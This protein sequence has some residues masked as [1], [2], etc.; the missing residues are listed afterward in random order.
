MLGFILVMILFFGIIGGAAFFAVKQVQKT[1]PNNVG[2]SNTD[3]VT[4]NSDLSNPEAKND[5]ENGLSAQQF[6]PYESI[7]HDVIHLGG[8]RYR[9]FIECGSINYNTATEDEQN[10][11]EYTFQRFLNSIDFPITFFVQTRTIDN[12]DRLEKIKEECEK[13]MKEYPDIPTLSKYCKKYQ[14]EM[15]HL[16]NITQNNKQKK[17]YIIIPYDDA[18]SFEHLNEEEKYQYAMKEIYNRCVII[19]ERLRS[20]RIATHILNTKEIYELV[21][22]T[23]SKD[24]YSDISNIVEK[25]IVP[26][27]VTAPGITAMIDNIPSEARVERAISEA[28]NQI[29]LELYGK[30][31]DKTK[32]EFAEILDILN[33]ARTTL[34]N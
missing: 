9:A 4:N 18:G 1:D 13:T 25:E 33:K 17:K 15:E 14:Y 27:I 5:V 20:M 32:K 6:L 34:N 7:Q 24:C 10:Q 31:D 29:Y 23:F 28:Q 11:M 8:N 22:S 21:Y 3:Y 19:S 16:G 12:S 2:N 26:S 30:I